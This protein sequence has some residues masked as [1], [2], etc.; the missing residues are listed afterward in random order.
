MHRSSEG[1]NCSAGSM[2]HGTNTESFT[3]PKVQINAK[4][5]EPKKDYLRPEKAAY[6]CMH[7]S[8]HVRR[9]KSKILPKAAFKGKTC[10]ISNTL[11]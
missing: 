11:L 4:A 7:W 1:H 2:K 3:L 6:G 9:K 10:L 5:V 8:I